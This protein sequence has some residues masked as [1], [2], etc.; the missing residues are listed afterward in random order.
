MLIQ[1]FFFDHRRALRI[2]RG[3]IREKVAARLWV[4][5]THIIPF[6]RYAGPELRLVQKGCSYLGVGAESGSD[7]VLKEIGKNITV[8]QVTDFNRK[9]KEYGITVNY[10]FMSGFRGETVDDLAST[11]RLMLDLIRQN[12]NAIGGPVNPVQIL[13]RTQVYKQAVHDGLPPPR[14]LEDWIQF[15][16]TLG[17]KLGHLP[18]VDAERAG[19]LRGIYISSLFLNDQSS[20]LHTKA[21][22]PVHKLFRRISEYR[23]RNLAFGLMPERAVYNALEGLL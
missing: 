9:I 17:S 8:R 13:P 22:K 19:L 3:M 2:I 4:P 14:R 1:I 11:I 10:N 15:N 20:Y 7:A 18:W 21:L 5:G 12:P 23:L 6:S 16:S